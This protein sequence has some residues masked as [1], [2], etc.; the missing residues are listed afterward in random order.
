MQAYKSIEE[1]PSRYEF[2]HVVARRARKIQNG[3][4]PMLNT[5]V[6]KPTRIAEL[7]TMSGMVEYYHLPAASETEPEAEKSEK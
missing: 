7:E 5:P 2:V 4:R 1:I 6:K 3:A